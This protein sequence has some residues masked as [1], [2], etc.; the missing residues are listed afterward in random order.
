MAFENLT[1]EK[2]DKSDLDVIDRLLTMPTILVNQNRV[3]YINDSFRCTFGCDLEAFNVHE[4]ETFINPIHIEGFKKLVSDA[5]SGE[6]YI[7]QCELC[8]KTPTSDVFW[9]EHKTRVVLYENERFLLTHL[10]DIND[11]KQTQSHLSKL[12]I[13][14]ESMLKVTQSIVKSDGIKQLYK[15]ILHSTLDAID[16]AR[17]GTVLI[18]EGDLLKPF[19]QIGYDAKSMESFSIP[20]N[21]SFLYRSA[22]RHLKQIVKIN[23]L[24]IFGDYE[25]IMTANGED[26]YIK[27]TITAP[28]YINGVFFGVVNVDSTETDAFDDDDVKLMEFVRNNVE[29][30]VSNQLLFEEKAFLSRYDSLTRLY[31]RH[32]FD[33]MFK[34]ILERASRYNEKFNLVVFDLNDLKS[35]NDEYGHIAGDELLKY[36]SDSCKALI[37]K[38]DILARYGGDEFVGIFFNCSKDRLRKRIDGHLKHLM[39]NPITIND[40]KFVCSY[41]YGI[42]S[43][44][45]EGM[46]LNELFRVADDRMYQNKIRYKLGFDFI[47][48]FDS[49]NVP[50]FDSIELKK[51]NE[52]LHK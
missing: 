37:R 27:S 28:V 50:I 42:S 44:G 45:E 10:L 33:D 35:V 26:E 21:E 32:Y 29:I 5:L 48:A 3:A 36:F 18:R 47:E 11:K 15:T 6:A 12:L 4:L 7:E 17:L 14:R 9:V 46:T 22:G 40:R 31:N 13:L 34:H 43:F 24:N 38:S 49:G 1:L 19:A 2:L 20:V 8:V 25:K 41:S 16:H 51:F 52:S 30:A 23:N 39:E